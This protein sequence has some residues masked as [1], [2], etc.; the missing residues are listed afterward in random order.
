MAPP[1]DTYT[2]SSG[3][4]R[5]I[6]WSLQSKGYASLLKGFWLLTRAPIAPHRPLLYELDA[7]PT[8]IMSYAFQAPVPIPRVWDRANVQR[9]FAY[10]QIEGRAWTADHP[11]PY[12]EESRKYAE[13]LG[14]ESASLELAEEYRALGMSMDFHCIQEAGIP[15]NQRR[16]YTGRGAA[17]KIDWRK[18]AAPVKPDTRF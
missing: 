2:C 4:Q 14:V 7:K 11:R 3:G 10:T 17:P 8:E 5:I 18:S 16:K 1:D 6:D 15:A 13:D 12:R 9:D